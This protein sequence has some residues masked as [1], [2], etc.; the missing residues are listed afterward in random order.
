MQLI[1]ASSS[2]YRRQL[3]GRLG[4]PFQ[5][6][7]PDYSEDGPGEYNDPCA[8]VRANALGKARSLV[9]THPDALIIGSDQ[10]AVCGTQV[11]GKPGTEARAI[12]QL[13]SMAGREHEL[14]TAVVVIRT[15]SAGL[16]NGTAGAE[17]IALVCSRLRMRDFSAADAA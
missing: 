14:L 9:A 11:L 16:P 1:L 7:G 3:L 6:V 17:K 12:E 2:P 15:P 13:L 10:T 4:L 5:A 8:M